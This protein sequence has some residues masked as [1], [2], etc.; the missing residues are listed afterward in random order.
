[1][2]LFVISLAGLASGICASLGLGGG[3]V[4]LLYLTIFTGTG[5]TQ[6]QLINLIF[7]L[8]VG[9]LS[10][11]FHFKHKLIEKSVLLPFI[12]GGIIGAI[13][14]FL[15]AGF[16]KE[17]WVSKLFAILI[18]FLGIKEL[19]VIYKKQTFRKK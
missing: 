16:I 15:I 6:A 14:G 10:L 11:I 18:L 7:F 12:S 9:A 1:M 17:Y 2:N 5:Q 19:Y 4:L 13:C 8:P 3:F